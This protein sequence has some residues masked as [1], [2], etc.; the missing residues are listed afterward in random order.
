MASDGFHP[1][2]AGHQAIAALVISSADHLLN[3]TD[4]ED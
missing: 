2:P 4:V 3:Q 1:S